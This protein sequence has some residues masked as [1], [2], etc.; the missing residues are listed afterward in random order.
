MCFQNCDSSLGFCVALTRSLDLRFIIPTLQDCVFVLR[1]ENRK[2]HPKCKQTLTRTTR[3]AF[4]WQKSRGCDICERMAEFAATRQPRRTG[5][6]INL[7]STARNAHPSPKLWHCRKIEKQRIFAFLR[8]SWR[9]F[10]A[11]FTI[12]DPKTRFFEGNFA[13]LN[14]MYR[15]W[16]NL[17]SE[18]NRKRK[19]S[20]A[21]NKNAKVKN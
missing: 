19:L 4:W 9:V 21:R 5:F 15:I 11:F 8:Q 7:W 14:G 17:K 10:G 13:F 1:F 2:H 16:D 3:R 12:L 6:Y 20:G 18:K